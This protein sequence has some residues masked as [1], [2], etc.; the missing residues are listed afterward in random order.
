MPDELKRPTK[1]PKWR[2]NPTARDFPKLAEYLTHLE[3]VVLGQQTQMSGM[4][5]FCN[6]MREF[7]KKTDQA[8]AI[9]ALDDFMQK[10]DMGTGRSK[11]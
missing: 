11:L 9:K 6:R 3:S 10:S 8:A 4:W 7:F 2:T 1:Q 5:D